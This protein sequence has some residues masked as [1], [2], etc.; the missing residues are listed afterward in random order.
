MRVKALMRNYKIDLLTFPLTTRTYLHLAKSHHT[1]Y[2]RLRT[3]YQLALPS[4]RENDANSAV[5]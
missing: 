2:K 4:S 3:F 5:V 1:T